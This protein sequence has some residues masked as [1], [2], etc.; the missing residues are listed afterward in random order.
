MSSELPYAGDSGYSDPDTLG[1]I[2][3]VV[4]ASYCGHC[5]ETRHRGDHVRCRRQLQLEPPRFCSSCRRR[6]KVQVTPDGWTA[7]CVKHGQISGSTWG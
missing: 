6:M 1:S 4:A 2:P 7:D 3:P 5:G